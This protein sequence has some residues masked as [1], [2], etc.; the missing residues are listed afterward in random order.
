[1][2]LW[3]GVARKPQARV[4]VGALGVWLHMCTAWRG[5]VST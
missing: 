4:E 1:M 3:E 2:V 5:G